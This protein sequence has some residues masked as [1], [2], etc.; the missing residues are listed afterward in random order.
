MADPALNIPRISAKEYIE[1]E[2]DATCR[3]E[4]VDGIVYAMAGAT[5]AH[6]FIAGDAYAAILTKLAPP[7]QVYLLEVKVQVAANDTERYYYPDVLVSCSDL[8]NDSYISRQPVLIIEVVSKTTESLDRN[9]K[10]AA[11]RLLSSFQEY[12]LV[13]QDRPQVEVYRRRTGWQQEL[14]GRADEVTLESISQTVPVA[15][16]YRRVKF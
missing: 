14:F 8:D 15:A 3:H 6:N 12:V 16:F 13:L 9:D 11:Y 5:K 1:L 10:F 7:C 2:R 4:F